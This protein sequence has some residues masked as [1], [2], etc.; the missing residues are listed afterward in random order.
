M[1]LFPVPTVDTNPPPVDTQA[2]VLSIERTVEGQPATL[3]LVLRVLNAENRWSE[4]HRSVRLHVRDLPGHADPNARTIASD[5]RAAMFA[6]TIRDLPEVRRLEV[7]TGVPL[8][9]T[10][11]KTFGERLMGTLPAGTVQ[12]DVG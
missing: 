2:A 7:L 9:G 4:Q 3:D 6:A 12:T 8:V 10:D 11:F 1:P 5:I